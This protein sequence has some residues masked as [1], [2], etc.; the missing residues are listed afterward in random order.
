MEVKVIVSNDL[1]RAGLNLC[2]CFEVLK[3]CYAGVLIAQKLKRR[4]I[5]KHVL[6]YFFAFPELI[7][8]PE[9]FRPWL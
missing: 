2:S 1:A 8:R 3:Y 4:G 9:S 7:I 6:K 5:L